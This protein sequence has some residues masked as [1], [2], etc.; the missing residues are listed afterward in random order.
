MCVFCADCIFLL[1]MNIA[2]ELTIAR[3]FSLLLYA[4][5]TIELVDRISTENL[6][7]DST[8]DYMC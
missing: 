4:Y 5:S 6:T 8:V 3:L 2:S 1:I 7:I